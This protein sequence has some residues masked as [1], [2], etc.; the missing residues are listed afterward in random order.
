MSNINVNNLTPLLGSGSSVSVSG[1]LVVKND[2]TI[3]GHLYIGDANTDSVTFSAEVSSSVVP[4]ANITYDLGSSAKKWKELYLNSL[5]V[6]HI[7]ASGNISASGTGV[8]GTG[9]FHHMDVNG[10][11]TASGTGSFQQGVIA[12]QSSSFTYISMSGALKTADH[13]SASKLQLTK[14]AEI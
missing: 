9:S 10:N 7:T 5:V 3:G 4:D 8:N 1:S 11:I 2:V 13:V 14:T 12:N 6:K